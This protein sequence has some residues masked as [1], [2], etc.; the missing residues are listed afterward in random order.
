[1]RL[2]FVVTIRSFLIYMYRY[3]IK[4]AY[5]KAGV[6]TPSY[7]KTQRSEDKLPKLLKLCKNQF[8]STCF[9]YVIHKIENLSDSLLVCH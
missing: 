1:M 3:Y 5:F 9:G 6:R 4:Y 8:L 7:Q 2:T